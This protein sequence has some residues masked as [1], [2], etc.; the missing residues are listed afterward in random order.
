MLMPSPVAIQNR[1]KA[2]AK[3]GQSNLNRAATAPIWRIAR[4]ITVG[5]FIFWLVWMS[6][7]GVFT[8]PQVWKDGTHPKYQGARRSFVRLV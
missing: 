1:K 6:I 8:D 3:L 2:T 7:T 5:Q 4:V